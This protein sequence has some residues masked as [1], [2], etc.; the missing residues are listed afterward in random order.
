MNGLPFSCEVAL[1]VSAFR[2]FK[3][4]QEFVYLS[5]RMR[6]ILCPIQDCCRSFLLSPGSGFKMTV[7]STRWYNFD[8]W[9]GSKIA[10]AYSS[11]IFT[12]KWKRASSFNGLLEKP[13][14]PQRI[15]ESV[16][17]QMSDVSHVVS[18]LPPFT[19]VASTRQ[20]ALLLVV[21]RAYL[22]CRL[23]SSEW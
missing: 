19:H 12:N 5:L 21:E 23:V 17:S 7:C 16:P 22:T 6:G 9:K 11:T 15:G 10:D 8:R 14:L 3:F 2:S 1:S 20:V 4:L 13:Y 18:V